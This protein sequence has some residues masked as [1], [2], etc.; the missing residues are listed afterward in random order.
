MVANA[1]RLAAP[2]PDL[3]AR[4]LAQYGQLARAAGER[5]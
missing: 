1:R 5:D 2:L 3:V 4:Y